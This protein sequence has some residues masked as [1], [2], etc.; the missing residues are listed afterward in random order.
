MKT[1]FVI[2][3]SILC[4][5]SYGQGSF[6]L[7]K[8][9]DCEIFTVKGKVNKSETVKEMKK[10]DEKIITVVYLKKKVEIKKVVQYRVKYK[11]NFPGTPPGMED[12]LLTVTEDLEGEH[13]SIIHV[14]VRNAKARI[15]LSECLDK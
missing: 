11:P 15:F 8:N 2:L 10:Y 12:K 3:I 13:G 6:D 1:L 9:K 7:E 5:S 4:I 14:P